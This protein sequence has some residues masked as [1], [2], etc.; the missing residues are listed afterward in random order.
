MSLILRL[1]S[2]LDKRPDPSIS[3]VEIE[4]LN[5]VL[6]FKIIPYDFNIDLLLERWSLESCSAALREFK[7]LELKV[8]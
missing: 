5:N 2:S 4:L 7:N 6:S 1:A 3:S 8:C